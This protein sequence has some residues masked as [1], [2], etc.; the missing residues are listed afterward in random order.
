M[1]RV[2]H[3]PIYINFFPCIPFSQVNCKPSL[4][5]LGRLA[6]YNNLT[7]IV[8]WTFEEAGRYLETYKAYEF[9]PPDII[10]HRVESDHLSKVS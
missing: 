8:A 9:K 6:M 5:E 7:M 2:V 3:I 1:E 4:K 10:Q